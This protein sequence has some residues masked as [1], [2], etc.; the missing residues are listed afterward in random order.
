[1]PGEAL[2]INV[3]G[4]DAEARLDGASALVMSGNAD[5]AIVAQFESLVSDLHVALLN[6]RVPHLDIDIKSLEFMNASCFNVLVTWVST[7]NDLPPE[8]RYQ[9]RFTTNPAIPWQRRSIRT[10]SCFAT[11]LVLVE[12]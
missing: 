6:A 1:M 2:T 8:Q 10:L 3:R 12:S 7:I 9:L 4:F 11:D 5:S